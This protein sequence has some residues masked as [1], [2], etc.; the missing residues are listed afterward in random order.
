MKLNWGI[1]SGDICKVKCDAIVNAANPTLLG[2]AGVDGAIHDAAGNRLVCHIMKN[3]KV[4]KTL[5]Q[6]GGY[7]VRCETGNVVATPSF[8]MRNC[9]YILHTVGPIWYGGKMDEERQLES[10]YRNCLNMAESMG[11]TSIAFPCISAGCYRYPVNMAADVA[12]RTVKSWLE[13][14][15]DSKMRVLFVVFDEPCYTAWENFIDYYQNGGDEQK[16]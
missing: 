7:P 8:N 5:P 15:A 13:S 6:C 9:K 14:H 1:V 16:K 12:V 4:I 2:G 3:V 11:L 10:C